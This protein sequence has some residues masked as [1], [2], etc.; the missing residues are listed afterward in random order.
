MAQWMFLVLEPQET[1][2]LFRSLKSIMGSSTSPAQS[3]AAN[4]A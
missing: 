3:T 1:N 4:H 2:Q